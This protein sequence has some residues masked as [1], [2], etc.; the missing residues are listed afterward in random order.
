MLRNQK[1]PGTVV[2]ANV[3]LQ[4][5]LKD[6]FDIVIHGH[7]EGEVIS[8]QTVTVAENASIKGPVT[9]QVVL[10]SGTVRGAVD[11]KDKLEILPTGR[12]H[13]SI[14]TKTLIIHS[15]AIFNGK[16]AMETRDDKGE[17]PEDKRDAIKV[18]SGGKDSESI[19]SDLQAEIE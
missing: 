9:A 19:F 2:G 7:V 4:G 5:T 15:G 12:L 17:K 1:G 6:T 10:Q 16:S 11:A 8:D 14:A 18:T 13:G 3:R